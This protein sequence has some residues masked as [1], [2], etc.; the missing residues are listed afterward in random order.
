MKAGPRLY[1]KSWG[2]EF[3]RPGEVLFRLWSPGIE[4]IV[5][6]IDGIAAPMGRRDD[7]WHELLADGVRTGARYGFR[8]PGGPL[9]PDPAARAQLA[10]VH[11][12]SIVVDPTAYEWKNTD[13]NG[14]PW[15][16]S[17]LYELNIGAFTPEG[18][19]EAAI[20]K[21]PHL[22]ELGVT[23]VEIMPV[24]QFAGTR[25]WG[26]DGVLHYAPHNA[27]GS[28]DGLKALV[29]A[30]HGHGLSVLLDVVYNHFGAEGGHIHTLCPGFFHPE[31][32]TPWGAAIAFD[33]QPVRDFFIENALYWLTEFA[34]DG[35]RMDAVNH[36][37]D[38]FLFE[39]GERVHAEGFDRPVH[40]VTEDAR[41][42]VRLH[43]ERDGRRLYTATWNDDFHHPAHVVLTG[44]GD[45]YY[46][47]FAHDPWRLLA[48][49]LAEGFAY[50]G[51]AVPWSGEKVGEPSAHMPPATFVQ[52]IQNHDQIG[53]RAFGDRLAATVDPR[54]LRLMQAL[55]ILSPQIP[56]L[57]MGEEWNETNPFLFFCDMHGDL[58]A[59]IAEG[60]RKEF[61][62]FESFADVASQ[63]P[64]PNAPETFARSRIDWNRLA[65]REGREK[66]DFL[67]EL[68]AIRRKEIAPL[69][70]GAA[71]HS[72]KA[73]A[74]GDRFLAVDWSLGGGR[75]QLR[76]NFSD[77]A[78]ALPAGEGRIL[79]ADLGDS[80]PAGTGQFPG[81]SIEW[82]LAVF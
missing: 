17:V 19:F 47:D 40:L 13:W 20:A 36:T 55:L 6:E 69:L 51:E 70:A 35:L 79:W 22:L 56:M 7:G 66:F 18:T 5:V 16:E 28:P 59:A 9:L 45:G 8:L 72:G 11:G 3:V 46:E 21:L 32:H 30:A 77:A 63:I 73:L 78:A 41:H 65:T 24:A 76:A 42:T 27:Y 38:A 34:F 57:F 68:I 54:Q 12:P 60:R 39:L 53:N 4:E 44:E 10:N 2:A 33:R 61:G 29:D 50:Q 37:D 14:R 48:R 74:S 52:F 71:P 26:Y 43:E 1:P 49:A 31:D 75:L 23:A 15:E 81:L 25:G 67:Q 62:R 82:R 80:E 58:G 64:D